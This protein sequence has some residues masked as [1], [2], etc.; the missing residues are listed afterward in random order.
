VIYRTFHNV[1]ND[2][3]LAIHVF[4]LQLERYY[5]ENKCFP[6]IIYWQVDEGSENSNQ[7]FLALC[8]LLVALRIVRE[9]RLTRL[10]VGH[11][12]EDIDAR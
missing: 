10:P 12:H 8:E 4:L 11:T 1:K 7:Y 6:W 3:N 9:I 2:S 5:K